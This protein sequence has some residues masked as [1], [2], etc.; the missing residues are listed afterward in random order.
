M[1][2]KVTSKTI[3]KRTKKG[4]SSKTTANISNES[5]SNTN[6]KKTT[7]RYGGRVKYKSSVLKT[8]PNGNV[9]ST[10]S[11]SKRWGKGTKVKTYKGKRAMRKHNRV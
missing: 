5:G 2:D 11:K 8:T 6:I 1:S 10:V 4:T 3:K 9:T 7:N